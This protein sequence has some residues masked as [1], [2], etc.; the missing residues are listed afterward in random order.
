[1]ATSTV[2]S[3][4][5]LA[6]LL[7]GLASVLSVAS[8]D[9]A[10]TSTTQDL[11][12]FLDQYAMQVALASESGPV[13]F[14]YKVVP[15]T[16]EA[17]LNQ[18][19]ENTLKAINVQGN[20]LVVDQTNYGRL[21]FKDKIAYVTCDSTADI[22]Y[23]APN[24]VLNSVMTKQPKAIL[25]FS[26][27]GASCSLEGTDLV[28]TSIWS[29]TDRQDASWTKNMTS[30]SG[31]IRATIYGNDTD[32]DA[33]NGQSQGGS[34]SA[35]A[36]SIL[37]SITGLITLL[38]LIII[39]TGAVRAHRHPERYGPRASYGGRPRQ[40]RAKG[41]ARAVLETLP[42]VK[43]G[44]PQPPKPDPENELESISGDR[45]RSVSSPTQHEATPNDVDHAGSPPD[46]VA[47][48]TPKGASDTPGA[49]GSGESKG[50]NGQMEDDH[51]GCSICTEDFAVGQDVRVLPCDH[52]FHP[53][54]IDPW[55]VNVSGTCPLC[56][57]DLRPQEEEDDETS[58]PATHP[59]AAG[60]GPV[61]NH[62]APPE[63][64]VDG[65]QRR[66]RSR[67]L[68]WNRLR[69]ASVDERIHALRQ[70]RQSQQGPSSGDGSVEEQSRH[71]KLS[72]RLREKFHIRTRAHPPSD[73]PSTS[74]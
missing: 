20:M 23:L 50:R 25:L 8:A 64:E 47:M 7:I 2:A 51:L 32:T 12:G 69:H 4:A 24:D 74:R 13:E 43:F 36:M 34:N 9:K 63:D 1:M 57:L 30:D 45:Q 3:V 10:T 59:D 28:F 52:K 61:D 11:P 73:S 19:N 41:L 31:E 56:R 60:D 71:A 66:R 39:A 54:C 72:D 55:L 48:T 35:V 70:Y 62:L 44:D 16:A 26:T 22:S 65:V 18:T 14:T 27:I 6:Y 53:Q 5:S 33:G 40:S 58:G 37:Y 67:L 21:D 42:I 38:F 29:M 49:S 68:D 15:L 46:V 17:G